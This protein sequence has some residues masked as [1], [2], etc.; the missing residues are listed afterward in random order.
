[1]QNMPHHVKAMDLNLLT[2]MAEQISGENYSYH[3]GSCLSL[4]KENTLS[5]NVFYIL[6]VFG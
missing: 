3:Q 4:V 5:Y 2:Q 1:M 6:D